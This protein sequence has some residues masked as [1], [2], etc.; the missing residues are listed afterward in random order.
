MSSYFLLW[1]E[2]SGPTIDTRNACGC[3]QAGCLSAIHLIHFSVLPERLR[4]ELSMRATLA[5]IPILI[6]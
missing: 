1:C 4:H 5:A 3:R 2:A 6:D